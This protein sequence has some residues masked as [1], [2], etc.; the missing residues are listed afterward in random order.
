MSWIA[1]WNAEPTVYVSDRHRQVHY[2][3]VARDIVGVLPGQTARVVDYGCGDALSAS[4]VAD[5]CAH[6][7]LCDG[8]EAVRAR[9]AERYAGRLNVG[10]I[11]P[12]QFEQLPDGGVDLIVV[13][14]VVQY[15]S[16]LEL[17]R[18]LTIARRQ[19]RPDG[20]LLLADIVPPGVGPLTDAAALLRFAGAH[21][22]LLSACAGLVRSFFSSY[23]RTRREYG[24]LRFD[25]GQIIDLLERSGFRAQR[26]YPNL[27]HNQKRMALLARPHSEQPQAQPIGTLPPQ[28]G[29]ASGSTTAA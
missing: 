2:E 19:L 18:L 6:L 23:R 29:A 20:A 22:L 16:M 15:L 25:E 14:S 28:P 7:Y 27:G 26:H 17:Q 3:T 12:Q 11:S 5:R 10:I 1:Y 21:G 24:L 4:L 8:A 9:L 13:N